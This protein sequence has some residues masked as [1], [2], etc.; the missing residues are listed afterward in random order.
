MNGKLGRPYRFFYS[1]RNYV[2]G[3]SDILAQVKKPDGSLHGNYTLSEFTGGLFDG[4][5]YF[6]ILS[7]QNDPAGEYT[8]AIVEQT[9]GHKTIQKV[10]LDTASVD[11]VEVAE[12]EL[13][14]VLKDEYINASIVS[15]STLNGSLESESLSAKVEDSKISAVIQ[16]DSLTA[17][18]SEEILI[19]KLSECNQ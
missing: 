7:T 4:T 3:L 9:S 14:G 6:N 19:G 5:Y 13:F 15:Q 8:V 10:T 12:P 17:N 1:A 18:M 2:T 16:T 11:G